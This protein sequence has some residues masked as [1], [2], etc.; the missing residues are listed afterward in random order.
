MKTVLITGATSGIGYELA[1]V[2]S[3]EKYEIVIVSSNA[4]RLEIT[5]EKLINEFGLKV[6]LY[7]ED[8]SIIGAAERLYNKLKKDGLNIDVLINNAGYGLVGSTSEIG[9][10]IDEKMMTLN[11]INLVSLTKLFIKDM[12]KRNSGM[13]LNVASIGGFQPGPYTST[14]FASKAFV[15]NY[16]KA[17]RYESKNTNVKICVL[18]PGPT[19]TDF[20]RKE[21]MKVPPNAMSAESVAAYAFKKLMKNKEIIIPGLLNQLLIRFPTKLKMINVAKN[22]KR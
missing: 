18:C 14:Y 16:S 12:Y 8:L 17:I 19:K 21:G 13:I 22:K 5:K 4:E 7:V 11:V 2:F 10:E 1:R 15:I 9:I 3:R 20:F 6:Y